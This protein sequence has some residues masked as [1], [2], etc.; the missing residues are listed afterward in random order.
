MSTPAFDVGVFGGNDRVLKITITEN[1]GKQTD[2]L[3]ILLDNRDFAIQAPPHGKKIMPMIGYRETGLVPKGIFT[4]DT[5]GVRGP[6]HTMT[7]TAKSAEQD[8]THKQHRTTK[9]E[10][11]TLGDIIGKMAKRNGLTAEV[12]PTL[13]SIK[14]PYLHQTEESDSHFGTRL[15][16]PL[17]AVS[18]IKNGKWLFVPRAGGSSASGQSMQA[19]VLSL[20]D[21]IDY[22]VGFN[23]R[24]KH[25]QSRATW[26]NKSTGKSNTEKSSGGTGKA[27]S[28]VRHHAVNQDHAQRYAE[29]N[30]KRLKRMEGK[31]KVRITGN[32]AIAAQGIVQFVTGNETLDKEWVVQSVTHTIESPGGFITEIHGE[33]KDGNKK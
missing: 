12:D 5:V 8:N 18:S 32:A 31:F 7:I 26:H 25:G 17:D 29:A 20:T 22:D 6:P 33:S 28:G 16:Y 14:F 15:A 13:A 9:Y 4:V 21:L 19:I 24:A 30:S 3:T 2:T 27:S 23:D 1:S 10:K 11:Q